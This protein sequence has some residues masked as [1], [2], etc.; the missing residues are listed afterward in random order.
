MYSLFL[1]LLAAANLVVTLWVFR[2]WQQTRSGLILFV[3]L[4]LA[5]APYETLV[6]GLGRFIG[7]GDQLRDLAGFPIFWWAF[8]LP[9]ALFTFATLCRRLGFWWARIDWGHGLVCI[10]AVVLLLWEL[11]RVY[12][13]KRIWAGCWQDVVFYVP[14]VPPGQL[15]AGAGEPGDSP[16]AVWLAPWIVFGA[17]AATGIALWITRRWPWLAL[18][19]GGGLALLLVPATVAGPLPGFLGRSLCLWGMAVAA[20]HYAHLMSPGGGAEAPR[21]AGT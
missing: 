18:L 9:L 4:P 3:L 6:A 8:T 19:A 5:A 7:V 14:V 2:R 20:V 13:T 16:A 15:C 10:G 21:T 11:P 17:F 1:L 12:G